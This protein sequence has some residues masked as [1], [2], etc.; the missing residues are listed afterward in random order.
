MATATTKGRKKRKGRNPLASFAVVTVAERLLGLLPRGAHDPEL[1]I[2][3]RDLKAAL[4]GLG[5][6]VGRF[7]GLGPVGIGRRLDFRFG[8][9][10]G[11]AIIYLGTARKK[12]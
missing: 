10:P 8:T 2:R 6:E 7:R 1:F 4:E 5:F 12:A 11:T 9:H 3:P